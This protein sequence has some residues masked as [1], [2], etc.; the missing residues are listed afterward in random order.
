MYPMYSYPSAGQPGHRRSPPLLKDFAGAAGQFPSS[1]PQWL[2]GECW[3]VKMVGFYIM[4]G[5]HPIT[6]DNNLKHDF[7]WRGFCW[8]WLCSIFVIGSL[9]VLMVGRL[10]AVGSR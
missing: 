3:A 9:L 6:E 2:R 10:L 5:H 1:D 8:W 4:A 7:E